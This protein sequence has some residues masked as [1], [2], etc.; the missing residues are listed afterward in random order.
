[1]RTAARAFNEGRT[2]DRQWA[3]PLATNGQFRDRLWAGSHG[4]RVRHEALINRVGVKGPRRR[5]VAAGR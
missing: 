4:R 2:T 1:M 3:E 5:P